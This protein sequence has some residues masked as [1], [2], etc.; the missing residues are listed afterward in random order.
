MNWD[1]IINMTSVISAFAT[2]IA[3]SLAV[4]AIVWSAQQSKANTLLVVESRYSGIQTALLV[5]VLDLLNEGTAERKSLVRWRGIHSRLRILDEALP[6]MRVV[7][8]FGFS[9]REKLDLLG[10][11][12]TIA[13][14]EGDNIEELPRPGGGRERDSLFDEVVASIARIGRY[15][16]DDLSKVRQEAD[17]R[18]SEHD[19]RI[20]RLRDAN[21]GS[22]E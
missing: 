1:L 4:V 19:A 20:Q 6:R 18:R 10:Y 9:D 17:K 12:Q 22:I 7:F 5:E 21:G 3:T 2:V 8:G 13:L 16:S 15:T 11:D 14:A